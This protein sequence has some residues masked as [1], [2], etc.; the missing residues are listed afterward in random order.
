MLRQKKSS[1]MKRLAVNPRNQ[2]LVR[3]RRR[4]NDLVHIARRVTHNQTMVESN[5]AIPPLVHH[6]ETVTSESQSES[7]ENNVDE[8]HVVTTGL[9]TTTL[10]QKV[11]GTEV[12]VIINFD[13]HDVPRMEN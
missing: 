6:E 12:A 8:N 9:P 4:A 11:D 3:K 13:I 10:L 1:R 7:A 2:R 5:T